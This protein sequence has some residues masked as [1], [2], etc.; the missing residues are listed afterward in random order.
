V[1]IL[2][3]LWMHLCNVKN[4]PLVHG[5]ALGILVQFVLICFVIVILHELGH[6][7]AGLA[8]GMKLRAF[9]V[10][11][12]ELCVRDGR[13]VLKF[14]IKRIFSGGGATGVVPSRAGFPNS[15]YIAMVLAGPI[16]NLCT[17]LIGFGVAITADSHSPLQAGGALSGFSELSLMAFALNLLPFRAK[18][19]YSDGARIYQLLSP[20]PW[21]D[22]HRAISCV[23]SSLV[24]PMRPRDYELEA[25]QRAAAGI[26]RGREGL[27]L[28]VFA[29]DYYLDQSQTDEAAQA[30][31]EAASIYVESA[32]DIS[33]ELHTVFVF[34]SAYVL[35]DAASARE[36]WQRMEAKKPTRFNVDY[37]RA[38]AA[39][40]WIEGNLKEAEGAW[41]RSSTE[42]QKLPHA[43]AYDY[44]RHLCGLLR[45]ALDD[46]AAAA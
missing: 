31:S 46:A 17:G 25:I 23:G 18:A 39:L 21:G 22:Y 8:L 34:G 11:P 15:R 43:G 19:G 1:W 27:L 9:I 6:T 33:A 35:H 13:W 36:W 41:E 2:N 7:L 20:G 37:W 10:G 38:R 4:I 3:P 28:R 26:T 12:F 29:H 5:S 42:A 32:S 44:D 40:N 30:L 16:A 14:N 45:K 24:T